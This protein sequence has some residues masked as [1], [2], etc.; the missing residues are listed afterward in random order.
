MLATMMVPFPVTMAPLFCMYRWM[1]VHT[2]GWF[3]PDNP[4]RML[5]TFK[6]LWLPAWFGSAFSIFLLRQFFMTIPK[7]LSE[8]AKLDGHAV[9]LGS[10]WRILLLLARPRAGGRR[11]LRRALQP[12]FM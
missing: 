3:G 10:F 12:S 8:A 4:L 9:S 7:E 11:T 5:G 1:D 2:I 6:P